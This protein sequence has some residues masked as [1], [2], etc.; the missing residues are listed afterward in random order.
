LLF[1]YGEHTAAEPTPVEDGPW[2]VRTDPFST[3]RAR[4]DVRTYRLC[5]RTLMFHKFTPN[6]G[7]GLGPAE[8][9]AS[10]AFEYEP[11]LAF[12]YLRRVTQTGFQRSGPG[13]SLESARLPTLELDYTR[14]VLVD[15]ALPVPEESLAGL[16]GGLDGTLKQWVDLD[17]EGLPGALIDG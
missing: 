1:D 14:A 7:P 4:Y 3:H 16:A 12:T 9:V 5:H 6:G 15:R 8:L 2:P 13:G 17:G 10:T 11:G